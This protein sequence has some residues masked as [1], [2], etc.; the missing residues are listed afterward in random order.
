MTE[1]ISM[2]FDRCEKG[3]VEPHPPVDLVGGTQFD[4]T[5]IQ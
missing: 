3:N 5:I 2:I 1:A 4:L